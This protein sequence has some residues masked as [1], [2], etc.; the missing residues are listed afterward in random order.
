MSKEI[1]EQRFDGDNPSALISNIGDFNATF[2]ARVRYY[3]QVSD[4]TIELDRKSNDAILS[5]LA[6]VR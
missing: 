4:Y 5:E 1:L 6:A 3:E 2:D